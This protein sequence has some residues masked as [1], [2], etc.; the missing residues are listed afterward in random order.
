V[1]GS[2]MRALATANHGATI[3]LTYDELV[4]L[5]G[6]LVEAC[7]ALSASEF[8]ARIGRPEADAESLRVAL[9]PI[10]LGVESLRREDVSS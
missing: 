3:E 7:E 4:L 10:V 2:L 6:S 1:E 5:Y 9:K 8:R